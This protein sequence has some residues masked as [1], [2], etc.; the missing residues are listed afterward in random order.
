[1]ET[2]KGP[3]HFGHVGWLAHVDMP[4][5]IVTAMQPA[6]A[7]AGRNRAIAVRLMETAGF[8]GAAEL[9]LARDPSYAS[10]IDG[11][12]QAVQPLIMSGDAVPLEYSGGETLRVLL[13]WE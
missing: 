12:G 5:L 11:M 6:P 10:L 7:G 13:E 3:P 4:S 2:S 8:G 1:V 9:R